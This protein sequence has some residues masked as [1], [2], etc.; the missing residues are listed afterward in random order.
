VLVAFVGGG[1]LVSA[2]IEVVVVLSVALSVLRLVES[3]E[4][5]GC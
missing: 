2:C 3:G 1:Y 4:R 5:I